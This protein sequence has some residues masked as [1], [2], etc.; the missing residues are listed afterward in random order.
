MHSLTIKCDTCNLDQTGG[1]QG[2]LVLRLTQAKDEVE[3]GRWPS[4]RLKCNTAPSMSQHLGIW[5]VVSFPT[6][7]NTFFFFLPLISD[8]SSTAH[9]CVFMWNES[10]MPVVHEASPHTSPHCQ[11]PMQPLYQCQDL[12]YWIMMAESVR[13]PIKPLFLHIWALASF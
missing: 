8:V 12:I 13:W 2:W 1:E 6:T 3:T 9:G 5:C 10:F 4:V 11:L 7:Q